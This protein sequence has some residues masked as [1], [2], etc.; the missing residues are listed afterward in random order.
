[1]KQGIEPSEACTLFQD[2]ENILTVDYLGGRLISERQ[3]LNH[4]TEQL[5]EQQAVVSH[6]EDLLYEQMTTGAVNKIT[7]N[8]V[9]LTPQRQY[10]ASVPQG[11]PEGFAFLERY[12]LQDLI[13]PTVN[14]QT[15]SATVRQFLEVG[16]LLEITDPIT[17]EPSYYDLEGKVEGVNITAKKKI[18]IRGLKSRE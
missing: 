17:G 10:W 14:S 18:L 9:T 3:R 13:K 4:L 8:G 7:L 5:D 12:G 2:E 15:L 1:M 11:N 16:T 6:L